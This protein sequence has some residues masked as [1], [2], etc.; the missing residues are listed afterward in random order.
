MKN[1]QP[2]ANGLY[3]SMLAISLAATPLVVNAADFSSLSSDSSAQ[4]G[5]DSTSI[6]TA[7]TQGAS[8]A[9]A[10]TFGSTAPEGS[11]TS[12]GNGA[13]TG[14]IGI[15]DPSLKEA[16]E[17]CEIV[18]AHEEARNNA[19]K[20]ASI[21]PDI[22]AIFNNASEQA[23]GCFASTKEMIN[24]AV[25]IPTISTDW[26]GMSQIVK[27]KIQDLLEEKLTEVIN[28]G[29]EIAQAAVW[30]AVS[31]ISNQINEINRTTA[32]FSNSIFGNMAIDR[33]TQ[34]WSL[35]D[36]LSDMDLEFGNPAQQASVNR[37][38]PAS[39]SFSNPSSFATAPTA[40]TT[41]NTQ[42]RA[43][44]NNTAPVAQANTFAAPSASNSNQLQRQSQPQQQQVQPQQQQV[45]PQQQVQQS[46]PSSSTYVAPNPFG[47]GGS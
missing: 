38:Q 41:A 24:L 43:F 10:S 31:P 26:T 37:N 12:V 11:G 46:S 4:A 14:E 15:A 6:N 29:C 36:V 19:I 1:K 2:K 17:N 20:M 32:G 47:Q 45:Q 5:S 39:V 33:D 22:D 28:Q 42:P 21:T 30:E 35:S 27:N 9:A 3:V 40:S 18:E 7:T 8:N 25:E 44:N 13:T 16:V 34:D 23:K